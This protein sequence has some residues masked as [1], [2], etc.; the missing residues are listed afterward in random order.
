MEDK[1]SAFWWAAVAACIWGFVPILEKLGLTKVDPLV[2]LFYRCLGVLVGI[3]ILPIFFLKPAQIKSVDMRSALYLIAAG[4]LASF[5]AQI[6]FYNGLKLGEVSKVVPISGSYPFLTFLLG[7]LLFGE[8]MTA[9]KLIGVLLVVA[10]I[11][12]LKVA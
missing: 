5:I 3:V 8:S 12:V 6:A 10:G 1:M 2:G 11:W 7:I 9:V 4:F